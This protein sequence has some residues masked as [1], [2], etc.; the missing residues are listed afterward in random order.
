MS[1]ISERI[2]ELLDGPGD[3]VD[4]VSLD[5]DYQIIEHFSRHLYDSPNK[6]VEELVANGFDAFATEVLVF[7]PGRYTVD[8]LLV[9][10]DGESMNVDGLKKL[11]WIARSP[12]SGERVEERNGTER[13]IIGKFGIGKLAS[14][15]VGGVISHLCRHHGEF[16][17]VSIDYATVR[18]SKRVQ[19]PIIRLPEDRAVELVKSLFSELPSSAARMLQKNSWT[20]AVVEELKV[21]DL[22]S[23][24]L[25]WVLGNG[26]P[27]RPDFAITVNEEAVH[28]R[29][30]KQA[31]VNWD[32]GSEEVIDAI[33][34]RWRDAEKDG[35]VSSSVTFG[36]QTGLDPGDCSKDVPFVRFSGLGQIWGHVRLFDETL[37][38]F[39]TKEHGRSHGYFVIVRGRLVNPDDEKLFILDPSFQT[40]YRSQFILFVDD[41]DEALLADR[42]RLRLD[43]Q[44]QQELKTLQEALSGI[45]RTTVEERDKRRDDEQST[46]SML[47]TGSRIHYREPINALLLR[48]PVEEVADFNPAAVTVERKDIGDDDPI[49]IVAFKENAFHVN[50]RHPYYSVIRKRAGESRAAREF[51]RTFD[52]FAIS[53]RLLEGHLFNIGISEDEIK[54]IIEWR[55]GLFRRLA[56]SYEDTPELIGQMHTTSYVGGR[57]FEKALCAV[58]EDMGFSVKHD[59][60]SGR[61]DAFV[62]AT[63]GPE[64][65]SFTVEAKGSSGDIDNAAA[66]VGAAANHRDRAGAEHALIIARKFSGFAAKPDRD[67][68]LMGECRSTERVSIMELE[69][70]EK[71]HASVSRFSY[72]L[73]LLKDV[74]TTLETPRKKLARIDGLV[75][76]VAGFDY[77]KLLHQIWKRQGSTAQGEAVA[78]L[79]VFQ[80]DGWKEQKMEFGDFQR[81][82]VALETLAAGRIQVDTGKREIYLRQSPD[83]ILDQIQKSLWGEGHDVPESQDHAERS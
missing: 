34:N 55:E 76:P 30:E 32:F 82:L 44:V 78:Y 20:L 59:G 6:A 67:P 33:K 45:A 18:G 41:L 2:K 25:T 12:K 26:M 24:R 71:I 21:T 57:S 4:Q 23:G 74:F 35:S 65:Y 39:R 66:D 83:L 52:L 29:L 79:S 9:W 43:E 80:E 38:K 73:P 27:L 69:S 47:P 49:S 28:S 72:P 36:R 22:P 16:Y 58:L 42:Q 50:T 19:A 51:L 64:S 13:K 11:W 81:R 7:T 17:I 46:G 63:V 60:R 62:V 48:A 10:D 61:K 3:V 56:A 53:E 1:S 15:A 54:E 75:T 40:F 8:R 68:A 31:A 70:L 77:M 37:L 5:V 14:Y